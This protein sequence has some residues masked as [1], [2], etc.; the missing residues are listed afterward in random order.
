MEIKTTH[1]LNKL[2]RI[3]VYKMER[4]QVYYENRIALL[5]ARDPIGNAKL[6]NKLKRQL[7]A[8][9]AKNEEN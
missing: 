9:L 3:E 6:I 8:Y 5:T 7:R 1:L 2:S 4:N